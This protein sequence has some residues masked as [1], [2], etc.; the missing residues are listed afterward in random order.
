MNPALFGFVE[1]ALSFGLVIAL[2]G[3]QLSAL[4]RQDRGRKTAERR[5]DPSKGAE[6][7]RGE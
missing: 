4:R 2:C 7:P 1:M 5:G 3:W 6:K